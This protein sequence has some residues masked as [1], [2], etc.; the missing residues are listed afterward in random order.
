M[1]NIPISLCVYTGPTQTKYDVKTGIKAEEAYNALKTAYIVGIRNKSQKILAAG[2]FISSI[3]DKKDPKLADVAYE[4][5]KA[6]KPTKKLVK[7][8][9]SLPIARLK[10]NLANGTIQEAFSDLETDMLFA[11]F[12]MNNSIDGKA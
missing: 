12:Y 2:I 3:E 9:Y 4:I 5:F 8:I 1:L 10:I 7:D 11:D 6:H